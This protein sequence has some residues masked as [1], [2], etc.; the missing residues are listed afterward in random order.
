MFAIFPTIKSVRIHRCEFG[1]SLD[2]LLRALTYTPGQNVLFPKL[3]DFELVPDTKKSPFLNLTPTILS[4][5]VLSRW[6]SKET[7]SGQESLIH[8][9]LVALQRV[10]LRGIRFKQDAH[11]T[12]M[13]KLPGLVVDIK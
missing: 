9:G 4:R 11:I 10:T 13:S 6:W 7:D 5:M 12:S 3:A 2:P 1:K 8:N